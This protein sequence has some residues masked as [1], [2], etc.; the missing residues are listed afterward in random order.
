MSDSTQEHLR[1][2]VLEARASGHHKGAFAL[3]GGLQ[4]QYPTASVA[5][6]ISAGAQLLRSDLSLTSCKV[7]V[8]RSFT[9]EPVVPF[10]KT[11]AFLFGLDLDIHVCGF[12]TYAQ[13]MLEQSSPLCQNEPHTLILAVQTRDILPK[14]CDR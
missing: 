8:L 14:L 6:F 11:D 13:D 2:V 12:N 4:P 9:I 3:L 1:Q 10:L 7:V 5:N